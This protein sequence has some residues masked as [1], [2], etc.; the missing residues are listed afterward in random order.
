MYTKGGLQVTE[1]DGKVQIY[2]KDDR[3]LARLIDGSYEELRANAHLFAASPDMYEALKGLLQLKDTPD[4][5]NV[6]KTLGEIHSG[7]F[8]DAEQAL[9]KAGD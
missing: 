1:Y 2:D 7:R 5:S 4:F 6:R 8:E 9:A 3:I